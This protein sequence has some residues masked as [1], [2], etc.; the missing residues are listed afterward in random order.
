M[1]SNRMEII[2]NYF[3]MNIKEFR[4]FNIKSNNN[5]YIFNILQEKI[6]K[7]KELEMI[8]SSESPTIII[9][10]AG[11]AGIGAAKYLIS[12]GLKPMIL[13]ARM[14]IGGRCF[15]QSLQGF[16]VD[17]GASWVHSYG[18]SN[19][20]RQWIRAN[21]YP[22][23][24]E[25]EGLEYK[26]FDEKNGEVL[27]TVLRTQQKYLSY[28]FYSSSE[29]A[30]NNENMS[31]F[32]SLSE[33]FIK[34]QK[35]QGELENRVLKR[36]LNQTEHFYGA[37]LEELSALYYEYTGFGEYGGDATPRDGYG[38]LIEKMAEKINVVLGEEVEEVH[39]SEKNVKIFTKNKKNY[40]ANFAIVTVPLGI[41][42]A[43]K[44]NFFP[45]LPK[46]KQEAISKLGFGVMNKI[47]L[48]FKKNFWGEKVCKFSICSE[49]KGKFPWFYSF[50][51]EINVLCCFVTDNF[52]KKME[53]LT[54]EEI[55]FEIL[56][57][58]RISLKTK[59]IELEDYVITRWGQDPFSMGSY[60]F[61]AAGSNPEDCE[62][63]SEN[64]LKT[65]YF[66]GEACYKNNIGVCHGAYATGEEASKRLLFDNK[67]L[68]LNKNV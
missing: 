1:N 66:A 44:I 26:Y 36:M 29:K 13:E 5:N 47:I 67:I 48:K 64:I 43:K 22:L 18:D 25:Q 65:V 7:T 8:S 16:N 4:K 19:L 15:T 62:K 14:R 56:H 52:A 61:F 42:K 24:K 34:I 32:D 51:N 46:S 38:K 33:E 39:Y 3:I 23:Q 31:L 45:E 9:I 63:L 30:K 55:I 11:A 54:D 2:L 68:N 49:E 59:D 60:S 21:N 58:L 6:L 53:K 50:S 40:E 27:L 37:S 41:L 20:I 17:L 10:G 28:L 35:T 12:Q 57:F